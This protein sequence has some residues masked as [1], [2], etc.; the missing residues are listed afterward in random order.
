MSSSS[1]DNDSG[2]EEKDAGDVPVGDENPTEHEGGQNGSGPSEGRIVQLL[3][4][5][6]D[7]PPTPQ[8]IGNR[9][10]RYKAVQQAGDASEDESSEILPRQPESPPESMLSNPDDTPSVQVCLGAL[11]F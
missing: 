2:E 6:L 8:Q 1:V 5:E 11:S 9:T 4:E 10:N 3:Q 7:Q